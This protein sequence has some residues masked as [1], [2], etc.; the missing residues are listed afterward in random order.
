[1]TE[2]KVH[3]FEKD[4]TFA[5]GNDNHIFGQRVKTG[6]V[7][8]ITHIAAGFTNIATTEFAELGFWDGHAYKP[9]ATVA[10][11][12]TGGLAHWDGEILLREQQY[13]YAYLADVA[14][15]EVMKLRAYG[16]YV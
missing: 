1:M 3:Q 14:D 8:R 7:L 12:K 16:Q 6:Q 2:T 13:V 10:P 9:L 15:G 4:F 5:T 11:A